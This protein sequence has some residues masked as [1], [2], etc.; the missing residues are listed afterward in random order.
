MSSVTK[1]DGI[2]VDRDRGPTLRSVE[3]EVGRHH[4]GGEQGERRFAGRGRA[5]IEVGMRFG[6]RTERHHDLVIGRLPDRVVMRMVSG[7]VGFVR[8]R[9]PGRGS[10]RHAVPDLREENPEAKGKAQNQGRKARPAETL[11]DGQHYRFAVAPATRP[12]VGCWVLGAG[13]W[14][15]GMYWCWVLALGVP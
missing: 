12:G 6:G 15:L 5:Q 3:R 11:H 13:Y 4:T 2:R 8:G 10:V 1:G 9:V 14:V 7:I